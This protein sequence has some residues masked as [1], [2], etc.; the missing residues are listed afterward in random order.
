MDTTI[1]VAVVGLASAVVGSL[2]T[3]AYQRD[4]NEADTNE[5]IRKTV[6]GLIDPLNKRITEQ[7]KKIKAQD[8]EISNLQSQLLD[9]KTWA[10]ALVEQ[11][12]GLGCHEP[13]PFKSSKGK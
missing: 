3:G 1:I 2:I 11:L 5:V 7:D 13:V 4:K 10:F 8:S 12:K 9:W 6:M